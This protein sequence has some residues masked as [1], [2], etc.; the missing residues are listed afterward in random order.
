MSVRSGSERTGGRLP[1]GPH[2]L[3]TEQVAADQ[4][5]R[6]IGA[7]VVLAGER[8]YAA[9]TVAGIIAQ[10]EVSRKTFYEHFEDRKGLLLAAFDTVSAATLGEV[11]AASKRTGGPT[12]RLEALMRRLC[13]IARES[14]GTIALTTI[15]IAAANPIGLERRD[16]LMNDYGELIDECL[17]ADDEHPELSP[18]LARVLAGSTHRTIDAHLREGLS[19]HLS[20][21]APQLARWTRSYHPMP[22]SVQGNG[23]TTPQ[24]QPWLR[25]T[26]LGGGRA[27]GTLAIAP[28]GYQPPIAERSPEFVHHANR[29]RILD[30]VAQLNDADGYTTLTAQSIA[31]HAD[32]SERAFLAHYKSKDDAFAA[33]VEIGHMKGQAIVDR[34]RASASDWRSGVRLAVYSLLEFLGSEPYFTRLAFVDAPLAGPAMA[35]RA[36]EHVGAYARL[37]LDG[38]PLRRRP[39]QIA[40]EAVVHGLFEL[41]FQHAAQD[42]AA[43]LPRVAPEAT[44]L[45][46]AP[47]LGVT[48]AGEAAEDRP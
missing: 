48:E 47:F 16:R 45:T 32:V 3:T 20:K 13:R 22:P 37:L 39:P 30:A 1:R 10:A 28:N 24:P 19:E 36:H 43:E 42:K 44:Y 38:A 14:P 2:R 6:L 15:E 40:R 21:L 31:E 34:A 29:E 18:T 4:R 5:Q 26:C 17:R 25:P 11:R 35:R 8:G 23:A 7:L 41:A 33:A 27:P 12:R 9:T 46:L